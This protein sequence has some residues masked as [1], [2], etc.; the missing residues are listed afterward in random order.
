M[1]LCLRSQDYAFDN[2]N[3]RKVC[4][5]GGCLSLG[6]GS[7]HGMLVEATLQVE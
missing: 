2:R 7:V 3:G 4:F 6:R 5:F 1:L